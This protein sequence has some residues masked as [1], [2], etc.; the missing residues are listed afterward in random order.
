MNTFEHYEYGNGGRKLK[1]VY[2]FLR[3]WLNSQSITRIWKDYWVKHLPREDLEV[4]SKCFSSSSSCPDPCSWSSS[5]KMAQKWMRLNSSLV[6]SLSACTRHSF[7][8]YFFKLLFMISMYG[9]FVSIRAVCFCQIFD[10][11]S[12]EIF[13]WKGENTSLP[14]SSFQRDLLFVLQTERGDPTR[15]GEGRGLLFTALFSN[16]SN[17]TVEFASRNLLQNRTSGSASETRE[18]ERMKM[19]RDPTRDAWKS[20]SLDGLSG[21]VL[22]PDPFFRSPDSRP[23]MW[24][25]CKFPGPFGHVPYYCLEIYA[26]E[27]W[28][29]F[30][31][32]HQQHQH[33]RQNG[34]RQ[35]H[36]DPS[37]GF[38]EAFIYSVFSP[39]S[40]AIVRETS[41][42][43]LGL[44]AF[45]YKAECLS[46]ILT[47]EWCRKRRN[48]NRETQ[49]ELN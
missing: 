10:S 22:F 46:T 27:C 36:Q 37:A 33:P 39:D 25:L 42:N 1:C 47:L 29:F 35:L 32:C 41:A 48:T 13:Q 31:S 7:S 8:C 24:A 21:C 34:T 9:L 28:E 38:E 15:A 18:R 45:L 49:Y 20:C 5:W 23:L 26:F 40:K 44:W 30:V 19:N 17:N 3:P 11:I 2:E 6:H 4:S 14:K 16:S 43:R 12:T